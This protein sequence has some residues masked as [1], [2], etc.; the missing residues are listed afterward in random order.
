MIT[1]SPDCDDNQTVPQERVKIGQTGTDLYGIQLKNKYGEINFNVD[2][3][4]YIDI[5]HKDGLF[6]ELN[7]KIY[8]RRSTL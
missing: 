1:V 2:D 7:R 4:G 8:I 3:E 5:K 6:E